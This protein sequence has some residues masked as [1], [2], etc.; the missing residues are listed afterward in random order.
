MDSPSIFDNRR[1]SG[2]STTNDST[3]SEEVHVYL[4]S[5]SSFFVAC[6]CSVLSHRRTEKWIV[7]KLWF[8]L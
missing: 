1:K 8:V 4:F 7:W 3:S 5:Q 2:D 6:M